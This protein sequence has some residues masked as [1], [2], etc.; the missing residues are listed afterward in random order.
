ML[1][2]KMKTLIRVTWNLAL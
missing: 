1:T 2:D